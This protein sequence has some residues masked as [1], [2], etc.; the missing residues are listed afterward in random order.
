[1]EVAG[2]APFNLAAFRLGIWAV[3]FV[4]DSTITKDSIIRIY[5]S[6]L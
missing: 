3:T 4:G 2:S 5:R 6:L 1:M